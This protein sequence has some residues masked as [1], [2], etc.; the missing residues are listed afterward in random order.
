[1]KKSQIAVFGLVAAAI[2]SFTSCETLVRAFADQ[3]GRNAADALWGKKTASE[4]MPKANP[5]PFLAPSFYRPSRNLFLSRLYDDTPG[6]PR[7]LH[8]CC[9][10]TSICMIH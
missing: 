2:I 6:K 3:T 4:S 9:R 7:N 5:T 8:A 10:D 1:M